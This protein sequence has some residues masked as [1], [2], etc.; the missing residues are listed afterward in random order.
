MWKH[1]IGS[2]TGPRS[3][4][5]QPPGLVCLNDFN[6]DPSKFHLSPLNLKSINIKSSSIEGSSS[7]KFPGV[8]FNSII[9]LKKHI[10][11]VC[12]K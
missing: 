8:K 12:I 2:H 10:N 1:T 7:E 3:N 6:A 9:T 4:N 5:M 11:K